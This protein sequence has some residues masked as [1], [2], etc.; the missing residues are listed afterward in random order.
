MCVSLPLERS[1]LGSLVLTK[2]QVLLGNVKYIISK[3]TLSLVSEAALISVT[4]REEC[5]LLNHNY[6][7]CR[8]F[9]FSWRFPNQSPVPQTQ[10][11]CVIL[12]IGVV[13]VCQKLH[14]CVSLKNGG[15]GD[16]E[17]DKYQIKNSVLQVLCIQYCMK[18]KKINAGN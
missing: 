15:G 7:L 6:Q 18:T 3:S 1:T 5:H 13:L 4:S 2:I 10:A 11:A 14:V 9:Y 17:E 12:N 16:L 8:T